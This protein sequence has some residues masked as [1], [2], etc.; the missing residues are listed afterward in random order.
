MCSD[1]IIVVLAIFAVILSLW[2]TNDGTNGGNRLLLFF[3]IK[4]SNEHSKEETTYT[5]KVNLLSAKN[6]EI[7]FC[8]SEIDVLE[9]LFISLGVPVDHFSGSLSWIYTFIVLFSVF[10]HKCTIKIL[11]NKNPFFNCFSQFVLNWAGLSW[12][13][14]Q[15]LYVC[16]IKSKREK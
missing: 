14:V 5:T 1:V 11:T 15:N 16:Q 2:E 4:M 8:S 3:I 10:V 9:R 12:L 13:S 6:L 7:P